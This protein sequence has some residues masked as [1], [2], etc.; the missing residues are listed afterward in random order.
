MN[1]YASSFT[2]RK[3]VFSKTWST[4]GAHTLVIEVVGTAGHPYVAIDGFAV[5]D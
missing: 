1:L 5:V 2:A 3:A 4:A